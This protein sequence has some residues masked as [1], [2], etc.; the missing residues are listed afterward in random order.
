MAGNRRLTVVIFDCTFRRRQMTRPSCLLAFVGDDRNSIQHV[1]LAT[2]VSGIVDELILASKL[3][4]IALLVAV[5]NEPI[6]VR[7]WHH[8]ANAAILLTAGFQKTKCC[9]WSP[10]RR[11]LREV[12]R[13]RE[14][15]WRT[16][17]L[18]WRRR[19]GDRRDDASRAAP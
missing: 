15:T 3:S 16:A 2:A 17:A 9:L 18:W 12:E 1:A 10:A 4:E 19:V 5:Q 6:R 11:S 7:P 8:G 13:G 14:V